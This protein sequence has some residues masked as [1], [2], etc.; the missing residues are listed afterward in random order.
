MKSLASNLT[1]LM[2]I[3]SMVFIS[4]NNAPEGKEVDAEGAKTIVKSEV[5]YDTLAVNT[6]L[7]LISWE[8]TKPGDEGHNGSIKVKSGQL[9]MKDGELKGGEFVIDM[10]SIE[11]LDIQGKGKG[12]L[13]GH[14]SRGDFFETDVYPEAK[15]VISEVGQDSA[16]G[17]SLIGNLSIK[18]SI[19]SITFPASI[20]KEGGKIEAES[21]PFTIDRTKW[22]VMYR[23]GLIGTIK[24]KIINDRIGL[25]VKIVAE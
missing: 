21:E 17:M 8:G 10:N 9:L 4:C 7:S 16:S 5:S 1:V 3:L 12:N 15:F 6:E 14:L 19:K 20:T 11:V 25:K 13:E 22:G 23:S 24:N 18:D 2:S